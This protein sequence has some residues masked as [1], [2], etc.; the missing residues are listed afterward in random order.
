MELSIHNRFN[1]FNL[2]KV[3]QMI[4]N[5]ASLFPLLACCRGVWNLGSYSHSSLGDQ[6][7]GEL[8]YS[9]KSLHC[10]HHRQ[11]HGLGL[12]LADSTISRVEW[13]MLRTWASR[14]TGTPSSWPCLSSFSTAMVSFDMIALFRPAIH[15]A[16]VPWSTGSSLPGTTPTS[17][18]W[19]SPTLASWSSPLP[20]WSLAFR[21]YI[22]IMMYFVRNRQCLSEN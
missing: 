17:W 12:G 19:S 3:Q 9:I 11:D 6:H 5:Q 8:K 14:S 10:G 16:Q 22:K 21:W 18:S 1:N 2:I 7:Q 15:L 20:S 4:S 13:V